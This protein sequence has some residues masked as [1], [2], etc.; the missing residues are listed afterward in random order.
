MIIAPR[1]ATNGSNIA[2]TAASRLT[3]VSSGSRLAEQ[4]VDR[5]LFYWFLSAVQVVVLNPRPGRTGCGARGPKLTCSD[6]IEISAVERRADT[7]RPRRLFYEYTGLT[8][9]AASVSAPVLA[10]NAADRRTGAS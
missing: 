3:T 6:R 1:A 5:A 7:K 10:A 4:G 9:R 2:N 8:G